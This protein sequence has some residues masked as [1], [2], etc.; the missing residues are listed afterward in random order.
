MLFSADGAH[1]C[2]TPARPAGGCGWIISAGLSLL[3]RPPLPQAGEG[4][5]P[6][7]FAND[8]RSSSILQCCE[9]HL[10]VPEQRNIRYVWTLTTYRYQI[11]FAFACWPPSLHDHHAAVS[12]A[13][14]I[15][16]V[17]PRV[18]PVLPYK[19]HF[20][21]ERELSDPKS[22]FRKCG[23]FPGAAVAR[24]SCLGNFCSDA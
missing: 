23:I 12:L 16:D 8:S 17:C 22:L 7:G 1:G 15:H 11:A 9:N 20:T 14:E 6:S 13:S 3:R 21:S 24:L 18:P 4:E 5:G 19:L 10:V 2:Q